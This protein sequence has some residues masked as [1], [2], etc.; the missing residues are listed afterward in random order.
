MATYDKIHPFDV[1]IPDGQDYQESSVYRPGVEL[2]TADLPWGKLGLSICY[3]VRVPGQYRALA[4]QGCHFL[5][6]P[7]AITEFTGRSHWIPLLKSRAIENGSFVFAPA[8]IGSHA[9]DRRTY[10]H[11]VVIDPWGDIVVERM[12]RLV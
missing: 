4:R 1:E 6:V 7:A 12:R 9:G 11:S 10:G 3:D 5:A 8:Q 2:V